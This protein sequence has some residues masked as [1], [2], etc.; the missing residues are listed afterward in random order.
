VLFGGG[1]LI[2]G[3]TDLANVL[4]FL[5]VF[6]EWR[7]ELAL[8]MAGAAAAFFFV[9]SGIG[10]LASGQSA[11]WIFIAAVCAGSFL[12]GRFVLS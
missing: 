10:L 2:S 9:R 6:G 11:A 7:P 3:K 5:D 12:A 8:V 4:G 1:L